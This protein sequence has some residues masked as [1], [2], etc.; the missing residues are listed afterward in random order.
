M[1]RYYSHYA[2]IYPDIYLKNYIVE[3]GDDNRIVRAFPFEKEVERTEFYSGLLLY[4]PLELVEIP[5]AFSKSLF[6]SDKAFNLDTTI[7]Y[8]VVHREVMS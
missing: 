7:R 5:S 3:M 1:K 4:I 8:K 2:F 6:S